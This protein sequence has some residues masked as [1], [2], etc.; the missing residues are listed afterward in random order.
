MSVCDITSPKA[1]AAVQ[2][3]IDYLKRNNEK[4][5]DGT[6]ESN[7]ML[8][9]CTTMLANYEAGIIDGLIAFGSELRGEM[10]MDDLANGEK[11]LRSRELWKAAR[12]GKINA[13]TRDWA[14]KFRKQFSDLYVGMSNYFGHAF[15]H[16]KYGASDF[17]ASVG[18][19]QIEM[20]KSKADAKVDSILDSL[21]KL[22][23]KMSSKDKQEVFSEK[24]N[25]MTGVLGFLLKQ[26]PKNPGNFE[27]RVQAI[28]ESAQLQREQ[29]A[30]EGKD[31]SQAN[32]IESFLMELGV[33]N[34]NG[35]IV[36]KDREAFKERIKAMESS[37]ELN[38]GHMQ[39]LNFF[40]KQ[41]ADLL[42]LHQEVSQGVYNHILAEQQDYIPDYTVKT[43]VSKKKDRASSRAISTERIMDGSQVDPLRGPGDKAISSAKSKSIQDNQQG[44]SPRAGGFRYDFDFM[45][46][47]MTKLQ[48][49][50]TDVHTAD[51]IRQLNAAVNS[52]HFEKIFRNPTTAQLARRKLINSANDLRGVNQ[53]AFKNSMIVGQGV[54][55]A[56]NEA[57]TISAFRALGTL[58]QPFQQ[59]IPAILKLMVNSNQNG[60]VVASRAIKYLFPKMLGGGLSS[61]QTKLLDNK[62]I[63]QYRGV[64]SSADIN[65]VNQKSYPTS[66]TGKF[67]KV[68]YGNWKSLQEYYLKKMLIEPD[69]AAAKI[70]WLMYYEDYIVERT[71]KPIDWDAE[72][73]SNSQISQMAADYANQQV[74]STLNE[75]HQ[76]AM[77]RVF[78]SKDDVI[79]TLRKILLPFGSMQASLRANMMTDISVLRANKENRTLI[80]ED[81]LD[82]ARK[83]LHATLAEQLGFILLKGGFGA[84]QYKVLEKLL[85]DAAGFSYTDDDDD[86]EDQLNKQ[87][88]QQVFTDILPHFP[89][90]DIALIYAINEFAKHGKMD[91][92]MDEINDVMHTP[93]ETPFFA[94]SAGVELGV[95]DV[96]TQ[97]VNILGEMARGAFFGEISKDGP[98][99]TGEGRQLTAAEQ[100]DCFNFMTLYMISGATTPQAGAASLEKL[101]KRIKYLRANNPKTSRNL[102]LDN[103]NVEEFTLDEY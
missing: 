44:L 17:L 51:A 99:F 28:L 31:Q 27:S 24:G 92:L 77:G 55:A 71:G 33:T 96:V 70:S 40:Q 85:A 74:N 95:F 4:L 62:S 94:P 98:F 20:G 102:D 8:K 53:G 30:N 67:M 15:S 87:L 54:A 65:K 103:I 23:K 26:D 3:V 32:L 86:R 47:M 79:Q 43:G 22:Q 76:E 83:R 9:K 35:E 61:G 89:G 56:A 63:A 59:F 2:S 69:K 72:G 60:A 13:K 21:G 10:N 93:S 14:N 100:Q 7:D 18:W 6:K 64:Q 101:F 90:G 29:I 88:I 73:D 25:I 48:D 91:W 38:P 37:G 82:A 97:D 42:P 57:A 84:F 39:V 50:Y 58:K 5:S 78:S 19:R 12:E 75:T 11:S 41:F 46:N 81:A 16:T 80:E 52:P 1:K 49:G 34:E 66:L 36:I 68:T 45:S